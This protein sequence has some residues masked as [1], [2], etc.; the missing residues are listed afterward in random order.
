[1]ILGNE[2]YSYTRN[3]FPNTHTDCWHWLQIIL[4]KVTYQRDIHPQDDII[5][6]SFKQV[7]E[8]ENIFS[9]T[10]CT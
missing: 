5:V 10:K 3:L 8:L 7:N 2:P 1:M 6:H 4:T 9:K